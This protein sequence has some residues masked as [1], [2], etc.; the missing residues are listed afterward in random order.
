MRTTAW[1]LLLALGVASCR[2]GPPE[3]TGDETRSGA[4]KLVP[5]T[6]FDDR[7]CDSTDPVDWKRFQVGQRAPA[8]ISIYWDNPSIKASWRLVNYFGQPVAQIEHKKGA[9]K[10]ELKQE[11]EAGTYFLEVRAKKGCSVYTL[12]VLVGDLESNPY[13]VPR[14]E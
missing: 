7:V 10:D 12:E 4:T 1:V 9:E 11:L 3:T 14:P 8:K 13:G 5:G 2:T 6:T